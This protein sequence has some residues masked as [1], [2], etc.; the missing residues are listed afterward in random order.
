M[1]AH[2]TARPWLDPLVIALMV[3]IAVVDVVRPDS[4]AS[5]ALAA[6]AA[7]AHALRLSGWRGRRTFREPIL[8]VLHVGYAWVPVGLSLKALWLLGGVSWSAHWLHAFTMGAFGTMILA[9]M[10]RASLGHT[11]RPLVVSRWVALSYLILT[12]AVMV[13]VFGPGASFVAYRDTITVAGI[14]WTLAF[15]LYLAVYAPILWRPRV[16]GKPG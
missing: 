7:A 1:Q 3:V 10:T 11:A 6:L 15:A 14:L 5:G 12:A 8:W 13:R 2:G 9:V 4:M 16:D